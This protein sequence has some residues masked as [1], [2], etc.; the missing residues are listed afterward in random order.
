MSDVFTPQRLVQMMLEASAAL[1]AAQD[2]LIRCTRSH[3]DAE[4]TYR[5][6]KSTAYLASSGT[7]GERDAYVTKACDKE[8]YQAHLAEGLSKSSLEAVRNRRTQL[9]VLQT[10]A[11][12]IKEE[13]A[14]ARTGSGY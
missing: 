12:S 1:D 3:S 13:A 6:A 8:A 2:E 7:V 10:V 4:R 11:N 14:L 5:M 9:S